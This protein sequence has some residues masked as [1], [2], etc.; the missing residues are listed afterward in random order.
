M[1]SI[2][3]AEAAAGESPNA[4]SQLESIEIRDCPK[5]T[6]V[7][8]PQL[9]PRLQNL[10]RVEIWF[11]SNMEEIIVMPSPQPFPAATS[12]LL[13]FLTNIWVDQC[14]K[15]KR[16]ITFELFMLLPNLQEITVK[17]CKRMKEVIGNELERGG[18]AMVENNNTSN[19]L[20]FPDASSA[21]Q[22][23]ARQLT[24]RLHFLEEL[25]SICSH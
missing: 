18:G 7:V 19:L 3:G 17:N 23:R 6:N 25:E 4:F 16:V 8:G 14:P 10:R 1:E 5:M 12:V 11:A 9:L 21:D 2:I 24:L 13:P 20:L 15:M 22:S